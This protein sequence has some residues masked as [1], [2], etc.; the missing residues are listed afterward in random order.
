MITKQTFIRAA[1]L[2]NSIRL[3][4]WTTDLPEWA[5]TADWTDGTIE[6]DT[7]NRG[8]VDAHTLRAIWTAEA[9]LLLFQ[10]SNSRFDPTRFL[11][12]CG[13]VEKPTKKGKS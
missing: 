7:E 13:L 11:V 1:T 4:E 12:A 10:E 8:N 6:I 5:L 9:F 2:V 3:G